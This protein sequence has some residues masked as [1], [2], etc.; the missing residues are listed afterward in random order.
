[1]T[2]MK[3]RG[4]QKSFNEKQILQN[5]EIDIKQDSR[6]GLVGNNG[7]GKTTLANI[8]YGSI[9]P[10]KGIIDTFNS[11]VNI[12]Y[13]KQSTEYSI[14]DF[15]DTYSLAENGLFQLS[16]QLGLNKD[17][18]W[19]DPDWSR[20]SGGEKLKISLASVWASRPELLILDEPTNHLDLQGVEWLIEELNTFKGA[21]VI[22]SHDRYFLDRTVAEI[23]EIEDGSTK[24]FKGDYSSYRQEKERLYEIQL[25]QYEIQQKHKQQ[26]EQQLANLKNWSEK[27]HRDS[28]KQGSASERRQI[29]Y[30][31]Y[32]RVKA[33]KMDNQIKS[34]MKRLNQELEKNEVRA[35]MEEAKVRFEFQE[36]RKRGKRILEARELSKS[37]GSRCLFEESHFYMNHGERMALL[38]PNGSGK[39]TLI[40][41]LLGEETATSGDVWASETIRIGYLSQDVSDLPLDK[42]ALEY[43]GLTDRES[44]GRARTIFANIGLSEEKLTVPISTLSLGERTR[45]KLVMM[46]LAEID[47]LILDEPT[48]HL[49]LASRESLEKTLL[50]FQGS[51]ITVSHDVYFQEKISNKLLFIENGKIS[52]KEYGMKE[53]NNQNASPIADSKEKEEQLMVLQNEINALIGR[54]SFMAKGEPGYEQLDKDLT[55]LL[56]KKRDLS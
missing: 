17:I 54:L 55:E 20:L 8:I 12:G 30:K 47:L 36:S 16:S 46:L 50:N 18:D 14:H 2:I 22:I 41:I 33:K 44:I 37:F 21:V 23:I 32:H 19:A 11:S 35:P 1:M 51:I 56:K 45:V 39:T 38:G 42:T 43:T 9:F 31:E 27:A 5:A 3:I 26:I 6:I 15:E 24:L 25:H 53:F 7:A 28:T 34:K 49:D 29:G 4:I 52:R 48:N 13:L 10:D 40:K